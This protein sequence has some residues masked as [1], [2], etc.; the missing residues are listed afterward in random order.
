MDT[1]SKP[2]EALKEI[3][4]F[5]KEVFLDDEGVRRWM[6]QHRKLIIIFVVAIGALWGLFYFAD[7][8]LDL[9]ERLV[10]THRSKE[11]TISVSTNLESNLASCRRTLETTEQELAERRSK[12]R[13]YE[14]F[15]Y[16]CNVTIDPDDPRHAICPPVKHVA[17]TTKRRTKPAPVVPEPIRKPL[18]PTHPN[19]TRIN[20]ILR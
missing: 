4:S 18:P 17:V 12:L 6:H 10:P 5:I 14:D 1:E 15:L 7:M 3:G 20:D 19:S 11:E 16:T 2:K 8:A 9:R 13:L